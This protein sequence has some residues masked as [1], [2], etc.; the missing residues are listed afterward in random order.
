MQRALVAKALHPK[1]D[2]NSKDR[3]FFRLLTEAIQAASGGKRR[4]E[5][6][7]IQAELLNRGWHP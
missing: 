2:G 5:L 1:E 7:V 3:S 6:A 4:A